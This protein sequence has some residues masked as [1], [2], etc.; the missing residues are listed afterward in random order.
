MIDVGGKK[1]FACDEC[2]IC[3]D[4]ERRLELAKEDGYD[5]QFDYCHCDKIDAKFWAGGYCEDAWEDIPK[6]AKHG[7]RRTG[8]A[9]RRRMKR[10][11]LARRMRIAKEANPFGLWLNSYD[12]P[13]TYI[14]RHH[15]STARKFLKTRSNRIIRRAKDGIPQKGNGHH[16]L[17]DYWW[18]LY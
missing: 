1:Y 14:Q 10:E 16:K 15:R 6:K 8:T 2:R 13:A 18:E 9:Y 17:F 7:R 3:E 12:E 5:F 4:W 11:K